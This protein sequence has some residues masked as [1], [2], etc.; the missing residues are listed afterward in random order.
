MALFRGDYQLLSRSIFT[1]SL[2]ID[3]VGNSL[4]RM[5]GDGLVSLYELHICQSSADGSMVLLV[6]NVITGLLLSGLTENE[7]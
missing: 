3:G 6:V 4:P 1:I 5:A 7:R 2:H